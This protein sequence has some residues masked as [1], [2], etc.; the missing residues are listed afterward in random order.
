[1]TADTER[2]LFERLDGLLETWA[3]QT[4]MRGALVGVAGPTLSWTGATGSRAD[5]AVATAP[6]DRID[7]ASLTKLFTANLVYRFADDGRIDLSAPLPPLASLP[8]FPYG[9]GIT[10]HQLLS[11][12]SGLVNYRDTDVYRA[13]P[14]AV[15]DPVS[16]VMASAGQELA[17]DP[18]KAHL[19]SSTNFLVLGLL[20]EDV[21]GRPVG[22]L[23]RDIF[24]TPLG[25]RNTQHLPPAPAWPRGGTA[26]IET[27]LP[28]LLKAGQAILR[29]RI[30]LSDEAYAKMTE[31][32]VDS[33]FG[34]GTFGFCPCRVDNGGTPTFF[35]TG[36]YGSTTLLAYA[37]SLNLITAVD[38]VDGLWVNGGYEAIF[39]LFEML[40]ALAGSN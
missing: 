29:D 20:L 25:L 32:D 31:I 26:G 18:G 17:N 13:D 23:L 12:T 38:L 16:G 7:L 9:L 39:T 21:T 35:A 6:D 30:G 36:Y 8:D 33:G 10:P 40:E 14:E 3:A 4:A 15:Y 22:D 24:F 27:T 1:V 37:P 5:T 28:D 11:H 34:A 19:Y 2:R